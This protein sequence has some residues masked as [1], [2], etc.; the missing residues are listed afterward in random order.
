MERR[1]VAI[2]AADMVG[3]SKLMAADETGTIERQKAH[4]TA[5]IDP[6]I[7]QYGGRIVK[8]TGDGMLVEFPSVVD[9]VQCAVE[10]QRTMPE[11]EA[12]VP[13]E[14]RIQYRVGINL[15]D[16]VIDGEDILGDGVNV[17]A[18]L[19]ALAEP[20][21]ICISRPVHTQIEGKINLAFEDLGER[22]V[23]NIPKPVQ[24][25]RVLLDAPASKSVKGIIPVAKRSLHWSLIAG[26]LVVLVIA[27][28]I[29]LW[30]RPWEPREEPALVEAIALPLPDKPS[31]AVL[32]FNNMSDDTSQEYFAD[33]MTEDLITDLSKISNLTVISRTSTSG[34]KG[35]EIDIREVGEALGVR[36]VIEGSVR[37]VGEQVRIN[38]QLIDAITGGHLWAERYD[39]ELKDIFSLQDKVLGKIVGSL[40]LTLSEKERR[41]LASRGTDSIVAHD[42]YLQGL[43]EE[44]KFTREANAEAV[45]LYEQA[46]AIDPDYPLPYARLSNIFQLNPRFGWSD[47]VEGTLRKAVELAEKAVA[48]DEQN[49]SLHWILSRAVARTREPDAVRRSIKSMERAIELDPDFADAYAFL[50]NLYSTDGRLEDGLRSI[51]TAMRMNPRFPFWYLFMRGMNRFMAEDYEKAIADFERAA[52]RSPTAPFVRWWLAASYVQVERQDDAEWEVEELMSMG[53]D[54]SIATITETWPNW[55]APFMKRYTEALRKAGIP[56]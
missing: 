35:R 36:Y 15:G 39:G 27:A 9:A 4:R 24:V 23:K 48:L 49:P 20:G 34:Y 52:E 46:L 26:G 8:T 7:A 22:R 56:E 55:P 10:I 1:L 29:A 19:E 14:Q 16:I 40:A 38:A 53:F 2:L 3:Y 30:Q 47:S 44:S 54:G 43:F 45:R 11:R 5:L 12:G 41:R 33:G 17:A 18:R 21:G 28:G 32:P 51:E 42:L 13:N 31:I 50:G 25:F 6:K 37:K